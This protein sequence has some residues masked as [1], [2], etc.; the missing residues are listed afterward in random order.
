MVDATRRPWQGPED[1]P[2]RPSAGWT[3]RAPRR[4]AP[5]VAGVLLAALWH[6]AAEPAR[7]DEGLQGDGV[8]SLRSDVWNGSRQ[9]SARR[10]PV[11]TAGVWARGKADVPGVGQVVGNG[12]V[13]EQT[14]HENRDEPRTR[15]RELYLRRDFGPIELKLGRQIVA[16]GRAD[17]LNP[18]DNLSPRDFRLLVPQD[19][20]LRHGNEAIKLETA[21]PLGRVS[22]LWFPH[23]ASHTLPL[24][25]VAGVTYR[26]ERP[27]GS[28]W[29]LRWDL[30][31]SGGID[32]SL[33][34]F[35]GAD[36]M[37]DL[38]P[39]AASPTSLEVVLRNQ[40]L[41]VLGADLSWVHGGVVW[42]TEIA[43]TRTDSRGAADFAH[44]KPQ[45][46]WVGGGEWTLGEGGA[47][48]LGLQGTW[49]HVRGHGD[50][51]TLVPAGP[52]RDLAWRQLAT[53]G[54]TSVNQ[55][56]V[57]WRLAR[58]LRN[59]TV[60]LETTGVALWPVGGDDADAGGGSGLL[61]A[62]ADI[63]L[64]DHWQLQF[65]GEQ[66]FGPRRRSLFG[67]LRPNSLVYV[68]LRRG[69]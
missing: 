16:W 25:A 47:T 43:L 20:D 54:Q 40:R 52:L 19:A 6:T 39:G 48:T 67:Q 12:W 31:S 21:A 63:G 18:T 8:L 35:Q 4:A 14:G 34:Y 58:R 13:R 9:L 65:G 68:Q 1:V 62:S 57:L 49:L 46:W 23:G 59:D 3:A 27:R 55:A 22:W 36:P 64:D 10:T 5:W 51:D 42:R 41:Q 11:A 37:P 15:V 29:A 7:G 44:K 2:P 53:S 50:P 60:T 28:Q 45:A 66:F 17:G 26:A 38:V 61:R 33:S 24:E 30:A 32:G 69:M 56:G